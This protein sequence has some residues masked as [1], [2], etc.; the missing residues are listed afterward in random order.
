MSKVVEEIARQAT[1]LSRQQRLDL[2]SLIL[3]MDE[4]VAE[5]EISLIW[6]DEILAR[7]GAI[8]D[9]QTEGISFE[10]VMRDAEGR[11]TS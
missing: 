6:E 8:D 11:L 5:G 1:H 7:I 4:D 3:E 2:A 9:G 10:D